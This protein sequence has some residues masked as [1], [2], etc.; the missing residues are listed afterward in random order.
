MGFLNLLLRGGQTLLMADIYIYILHGG[1][2]VAVRGRNVGKKDLELRG[3]V[4]GF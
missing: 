1:C 4:V 3:G 2:R